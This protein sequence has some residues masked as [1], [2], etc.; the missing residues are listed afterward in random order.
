MTGRATGIKEGS[1]VTVDFV[2][3]KINIIRKTL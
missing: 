2:S 3:D 1:E